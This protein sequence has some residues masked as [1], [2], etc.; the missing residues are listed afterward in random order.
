MGCIMSKQ[1]GGGGAG[2][3]LSPSFGRGSQFGRSRDQDICYMCKRSGHWGQDCPN[4]P[5]NRDGQDICFKCHRPGH[6][7]KDCPS[8]QGSS[9]KNKCYKCGESGHWAQACDA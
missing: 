2:E 8:S 3:T 1:E 5:S 6:W 9:N 7:A 4:G